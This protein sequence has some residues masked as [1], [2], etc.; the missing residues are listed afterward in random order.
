MY[1]RYCGKMIEE[2]AAFCR[3]CGGAQN[4][5][6]KVV[7]NLDQAS[8]LDMLIPPNTMALWAYYLGIFSLIC[9]V[10]S[11]PA[12]VTGILGVRHANA[13]PEAKGKVHAWVGIVLGALGILLWIPVIVMMVYQ[14]VN[15]T[16]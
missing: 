4:S 7:V 14:L 5:Q 10:A 8:G 11:I 2:D 13:H 12:L 9:F 3:F 16:V 6:G 1:C 15:K